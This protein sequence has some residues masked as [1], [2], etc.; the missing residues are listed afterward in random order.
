M[1]CSG[2]PPRKI[3][4]VICLGG[5]P[6]SC[7]KINSLPTHLIN[8]VHLHFLSV[9]CAHDLISRC[10][11]VILSR[12]FHLSTMASKPR[13]CP[14]ISW[15][16]NQEHQSNA[17]HLATEERHSTDCHICKKFIQRTCICLDGKCLT[18]WKR[19]VDLDDDTRCG[20]VTLPLAPKK[21]NTPLGKAKMAFL[22]VACRHLHGNGATV[23]ERNGDTRSC[24]AHHHCDPTLLQPNDNGPVPVVEKKQGQ[25]LCFTDSDKL[26]AE[27]VV[28]NGHFA[29]PNHAM[30]NV[31]MD[32]RA[33]ER[34]AGIKQEDSPVSAVHRKMPREREVERL[35]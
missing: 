11:I 25:H 23:P 9:D 12:L 29:A 10:F 4:W 28:E 18:N 30:T 27:D 16:H 33:A 19:W 7:Q 21:Q 24:V 22:G 5:K 8:L 35:E 1:C 15:A 13:K 31:D 3:V 26:P 32:L 2:D 17:V 34:S 14:P 6:H 20:F